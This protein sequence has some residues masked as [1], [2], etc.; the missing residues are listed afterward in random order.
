MLTVRFGTPDFCIVRLCIWCQRSAFYRLITKTAI[1]EFRTMAFAYHIL[2]AEY[3][4]FGLFIRA[5]FWVLTFP[6]C[7]RANGW[8]CVP[9]PCIHGVK[10]IASWAFKHHKRLRV[11]TYSGCYL[12]LCLRLQHRSDT[13]WLPGIAF[14]WFKRGYGYLELKWTTT[15]FKLE[16][17][18]ITCL[19]PVRGRITTI[20][21]MP[22][23]TTA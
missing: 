3:G 16:R 12:G 5:H 11:D 7:L 1:T 9:P 14:Q 15:S 8:V 4:L 20:Y 23:V 22:F 17:G 6:S 13:V 19:G 2:A 10:Y 21:L 18:S